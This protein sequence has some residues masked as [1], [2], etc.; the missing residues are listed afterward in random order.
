MN[1]NTNK[2]FSA[3]G[4]RIFNE[5]LLIHCFM[6]KNW[7]K[8]IGFRI[9]ILPKCHQN[10][11]LEH[12]FSQRVFRVKK[13]KYTRTIYASRGLHF[14]G[15]ISPPICSNRSQ[16]LL[17]TE[18][19]GKF[20]LRPCHDVSRPT[21]CCGGGKRTSMSLPSVAVVANGPPYHYQVLRWWR[22][23]L[24]VTTKWRGSDKRPVPP[25]PAAPR[26]P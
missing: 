11:Q 6:N 18:A 14:R 21:K 13:T 25:V 1:S 7:T 5:K 19:F 10:L 8:A 4:H 20:Q 16:V 9:Q 12:W 24:H 26:R 2:L 15:D 22:T 17:K 3:S 23:D